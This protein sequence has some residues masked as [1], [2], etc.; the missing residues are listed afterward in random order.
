MSQLFLYLKGVTWILE[1]ARIDYILSDKSF[2]E[3][4]KFA[5]PTHRKTNHFIAVTGFYILEQP[6]VSLSYLLKTSIMVA[7]DNSSF[8]G[9]R[10]KTNS[11]SPRRFS[12][13]LIDAKRQVISRFIICG[14]AGPLLFVKVVLFLL[15]GSMLP[16]NELASIFRFSLSF[17]NCTSTKVAL[18]HFRKA[19]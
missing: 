3:L 10:L 9:V 15:T 7:Q 6:K 16:C 2:S 13:Y 4:F 18:V 11:T 8:E 5:T 17:V 12:S 1:S 19:R 14:F